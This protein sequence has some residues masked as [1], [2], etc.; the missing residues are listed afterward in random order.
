MSKEARFTVQ[1]PKSAANIRKKIHQCPTIFTWSEKGTAQEPLT[2][3]KRD[4][5]YLWCS[6]LH[7]FPSRHK[8]RLKPSVGC[9]PAPGLHPFPSTGCA[10]HPPPTPNGWDLVKASKHQTLQLLMLSGKPKKNGEQ[11][12]SLKNSNAILPT[13]TRKVWN[14]K[15]G[16]QSQ[17]W[18]ATSATSKSWVHFSRFTLLA[19]CSKTPALE[20]RIHQVRHLSTRRWTTVDGEARYDAKK[21]S[22]LKMKETIG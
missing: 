17:R 14:L 5:T 22:C 1:G 16:C 21:E 13:S 4:P 12:L 9:Q 19:R 8:Q 2:P 18:Y 6:G 10:F 11:W 15:N 7:R 20:D 3:P